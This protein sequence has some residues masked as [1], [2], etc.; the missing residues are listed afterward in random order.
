[1]LPPLEQAGGPVHP[2]HPAGVAMRFLAMRPILLA[3]ALATVAAAPPPPPT[4]D[5]IR[6]FTGTT[7]GDGRFKAIL[8]GSQRV[9][10]AGRGRME[11]DTLVLDQIVTREGTDPK[12]RQWRIRA[13]APGRYTGTLSDAKGAITGETTGDRLRLRFTSTGGFAVEQWLTLSPDGR[14]AQ[15]RLTAK[16]FG[17]TVATLDETITKTD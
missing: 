16:R 8:R 9:T 4:F 14:S 10:V 11:G 5:A 7:H 2:V 13:T 17:V 1:M 15:N 3:L 6:F 12:P